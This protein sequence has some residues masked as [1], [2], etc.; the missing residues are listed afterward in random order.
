MPSSDVTTPPQQSA[1]VL[2][3]VVAAAP[4]FGLAAVYLLTWIAPFALGR[5]LV[6]DLMLTMLLEFIVIHS[7][8]FMGNV[9][10]A[11]RSRAW[12]TKRIV[13]LGGFYTVFVVSFALAFR[14]WWPL[15]AFWGLT[16]NRLLGVLVGQAPKGD[17]KLLM[18]QGWAAS[19]LFFMLG[20]MLTTLIPM[21]ALGVTSEVIA[22]QEFTATGLWVDE[23][24]RVLAFGVI[25][26]SLLGVS[27]LFGHRAFRS[28]I[29]P[30]R[31][32]RASAT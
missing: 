22:A 17:A 10:F 5:T 14:A 21:P 9:A 4:N 28:G 32:P 13:W 2:A 20:A 15:L 18:K 16:L 30:E 3:S 27:E 6:A 31:G 7:A 23:P 25:Y 19:V 1:I 24:Q 26:F 8:V 11:P 29:L 12:R